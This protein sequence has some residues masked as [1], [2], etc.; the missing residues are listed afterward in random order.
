[1][2]ERIARCECGRVALH[3]AGEPIVTAICHCDDCQAAAGRLEALGASDAFHDAWGGTPYATFRNDRLAW[4]QGEDRLREVKLRPDSPTTRFVT[5]C[6]N[7]PMCLTYRPGWWTSVYQGRLADAP[8]SQMRVQTRFAKP[9]LSDDLPRHRRVAAS[10]LP[11]LLAA[12]V[13]MRFGRRR[14]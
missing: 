13:T 11:Q 4:L 1:M 2:I 8:R 9:G 7:T 14:A 5:D 6:C 10:L 12:W 3:T